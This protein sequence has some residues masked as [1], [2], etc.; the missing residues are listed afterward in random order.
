MSPMLHPKRYQLNETQLAAA[1][2]LIGIQPSQQSGLPES[3]PLSQPSS[4]LQGTGLL[5]KG[6]KRLTTEAEAILRVAADPARML[7][8]VANRAGQPKW[9]ETVFLHSAGEGPFV[10]QA[11]DSQVFDFALLPTAME[12][13]ILIDEMLG[14]TALVSPP[15]EEAVTLELSG[16]ATALAAADFWQESWLQARLSRQPQPMPAFTAEMLEQ[17][18]EQGLANIDTRWAVTAG[19]MVCPTDLKYT[20]GRMGEGLAALQAVGL[21]TPDSDGY[22]LTQAG[23]ILT[24]GLGQL[25][26]TGGLSLAVAN[27]DGRITVAHISLFRSAIAIWIAAWTSV[28]VKDATVRLFQADAGSAL[29]LVHGLLEPIEL[30]TSPAGTVPSSTGATCPSCG[31]PTSAG[32]RFCERCGTALE[33]PKAKKRRNKG[34]VCSA[35]GQ[36]VEPGSKFCGNCGAKVA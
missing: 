14:L 9:T 31:A 1:M 5:A 16:Y 7:S 3:A 28:E 25:V 29:N 24:S 34:Q 36:R 20:I 22:K 30:P 18:L 26:N 27:G 32:Q 17:Q 4:V 2:T 6:K 8:V 21:V 11:S 12:V 33:K 35:C 15:G 19:R 10:S 13:A 23:H